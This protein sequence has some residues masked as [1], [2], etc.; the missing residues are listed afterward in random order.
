MTRHFRGGVD[1]APDKR[2]FHQAMVDR[3]LIDQVIAVSVDGFEINV[4]IARSEASIDDSSEAVWAGP[5][6]VWASTFDGANA[7]EVA[8]AMMSVVTR[9]SDATRA[10]Y[11]NAGL[12][13]Q[14]PSFVSFESCGSNGE[15]KAHTNWPASESTLVIREPVDVDY[16]RD[17]VQNEV[18]L[19]ER[20][21]GQANYWAVHSDAL[22]PET[23]VL[24]AAIATES[25]AK[26][27]FA[28]H[29]SNS[30]QPELATVT[31]GKNPPSA[32][33]AARLYDKCRFRSP[34]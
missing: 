14:P 34:R 5:I 24:L 3:E 25:Q 13:G 6:A 8:A 29:L 28:S 15:W 10:S 33:P 17:A 20:L 16:V 4:S 31:F 27:V 26:R 7:G 19:T 1:P 32:F 21:I 12:V 30:G 23:A 18:G 22:D 9:Y 11:P 2:L